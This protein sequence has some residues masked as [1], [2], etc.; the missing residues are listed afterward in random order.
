[1]KILKTIVISVML[2]LSCVA[3]THAT[4]VTFDDIPGAII[5]SLFPIPNGYGSLNWYN[6]GGVHGDSFPGWGY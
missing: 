3:F 5:P 1:M 2:S 6:L 4:V